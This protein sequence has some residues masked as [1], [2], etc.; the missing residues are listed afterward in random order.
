MAE[1]D[2]KGN[3]DVQKDVSD[4]ELPAADAL[5]EVEATGVGPWN[6]RV[7]FLDNGTG[8]VP[9]VI[10]VRATAEG[11]LRSITQVLGGLVDASVPP[12]KVIEGWFRITVTDAVRAVE[13]LGEKHP[14]VKAQL[15][16]VFFS[17]SMQAHPFL[18]SP[19]LGSP[20]LGSPFLGSPFLGSP[21][22]GSPF[23]GSPTAV[24]LLQGTG[25]RHSSALPV[26][27]R[28]R[29][30]PGPRPSGTR[31]VKVA[32]LDTGWIPDAEL[33]LAGMSPPTVIDMTTLV[34]A[35]GAPVVVHDPVPMHDV[36]DADQDKH[37]DPV[38]GHA[39]FIA[40]LIERE[41]PGCAITILPVLTGYGDGREDSIAQ[42]LQHVADQG[43]PAG[44]GFDLVNLSFGGYMFPT[45]GVPALANV[46][47]I[48][49]AIDRVVG[50]GTVVAASAGNDG[51]FA[52]QMPASRS[53]V[54][55]VGAVDA[56]GYP[57]PF[58]NYGPWVNASAVGVDVIS[59]FFRGETIVDAKFYGVA[60]KRWK[61][62]AAWSGTSFSAPR[63]VAAIAARM[64]AD[65]SEASAARDGVIGPRAGL[66]RL[67]QYGTLVDAQT[68][69]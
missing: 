25:E 28:G 1:G 20:F 9:G 50:Q 22:L 24:P 11:D 42:A 61:G 65:N 14:E 68:R 6:K 30:N 27:P 38:A 41:A 47:M 69:R 12:Q 5:S 67:P 53:D 49:D 43:P 40:G 34:D 26:A 64:M 16:H 18:G 57:A 7:R 33:R 15:V 31:T 46:D 8:Y 36:F 21:F 32:I 48:Q 2:G 63:V 17:H 51:S 3:R 60:P 10:A 39:T 23:L 62:W 52:P 44:G 56:A 19:F 4:H 13:L 45:P 35:A 55:G 37:L 29:V 58:S 59:I 66:A 54:I